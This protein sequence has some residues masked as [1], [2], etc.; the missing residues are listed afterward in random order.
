VERAEEGLQPDHAAHQRQGVTK[1]S[2]KSGKLP[3]APV[4]VAA[5]TRAVARL[6]MGP[7]SGEGVLGAAGVGQLLALGVGVGEEASD[8]QEQ[9]GAQAQAEPRGGDEARGFADGDGGGDEQ[10]EAEAG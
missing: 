4:T 10:P 9:D 5:R 6:A 7:E 3:L 1:G 8:G 2:A